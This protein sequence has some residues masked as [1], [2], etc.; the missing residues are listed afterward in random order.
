MLQT[1]APA[2]RLVIVFIL[3][4]FSTFHTNTMSVR[5]RFDPLSRAFSNWSV[6][7][8][9]PQRL[10][11]AENLYT[12]KCI[13]FQ[14]KTHFG[15]LHHGP[16]ADFYQIFHSKT[17]K[18]KSMHNWGKKKKDLTSE[19]IMKCWPKTPLCQ[20]QAYFELLWRVLI[21]FSAKFGKGFLNKCNF[22]NTPNKKG[23]QF[24]VMLCK[25]TSTIAKSAG[26]HNQTVPGRSGAAVFTSMLLWCLLCLRWAS[27][28]F[29]PPHQWN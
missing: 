28:L 11:W 16:K 17:A 12:S 4:A 15:A 18:T 6:F 1:H 2:I 14:M 3:D 8:E 25:D 26:L 10:V 20:F 29:R 24:T 21:S 22:F 13:D 27:K 9:N 5:F 23:S 19:N 7:D